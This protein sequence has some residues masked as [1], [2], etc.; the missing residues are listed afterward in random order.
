MSEDRQKDKKE[1]LSGLGKR[2]L[3]KTLPESMRK[4]KDQSDKSK[5]ATEFIPHE[6]SVRQNTSPPSRSVSPAKAKPEIPR[7][8]VSVPQAN[9][10][11]TS[12]KLVAT[13]KP[14][15]KAVPKK[16]KKDR[17]LLSLQKFKQRFAS[18]KDSA[19]QEK[20][21][22]KGRI[23]RSLQDRKNI[24]FL[25]L[26]ILLVFVSGIYGLYTLYSSQRQS[27]Y[28]EELRSFIIP[29]KPENFVAKA[30]PVLIEFINQGS[31]CIPVFRKLY[32]TMTPS[33]KVAVL[34]IL[35]EIQDPQAMDIWMDALQSN[36]P[37]LARFA[38]RSVARLEEKAIAPLK[39]KWKNLDAA[40]KPYFIE[41]MA[42]T[43]QSEALPLILESLQ[44]E[45]T[46]TRE[47]SAEKLKY[48][49]NKKEIIDPLYSA[50]SDKESSVA[51]KALVV[52]DLLQKEQILSPYAEGLSQRTKQAFLS[53]QMPEIRARLLQLM[54]ILGLCLKKD[55]DNYIS[56]FK[57]DVKKAF[58]EDSIPEKIAAAYIL[59]KFQDEE[60]IPELILHIESDIPEL[61]QNIALS[62]AALAS[63]IVPKEILSRKWKPFA[64]VQKALA[65]ILH[66]Y[67]IYTIRLGLK[68]KAIGFLKEMMAI[69]FYSS[70]ESI[71]AALSLYTFQPI[72][73]LIF[74]K[75]EIKDFKSLSSKIKKGE[76]N[77]AQYL[78]KRFS[79]KT[80]ALDSLSLSK[81]PSEE[82]K[83]LLLEEMN[84][85]LC[86]TDLYSQDRFPDEKQWPSGKEIHF[87]RVLIE[88]A[89]PQEIM[90]A[91][92]LAYSDVKNPKAFIQKFVPLFKPQS[93][94]QPNKEDA[95]DIC[96]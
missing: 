1:S 88:K 79:E 48:F 59:G 60:M 56:F 4:K 7:Q 44:K 3:K 21:K 83:I 70:Q 39:E 73:M 11:S 6:T 27:K 91:L 94:N 81:D 26:G 16:S 69:S 40:S 76:G 25:V 84:R 18:K 72:D 95:V 71:A 64:H 46:K 37:L 31:S 63:P 67:S 42:L 29:E 41:A 75:E 61:S 24:T 23:Y 51:E 86:S 38:A 50:L 87:H 57:E 32:P 82:A 62:L 15:K 33:Q 53:S 36:V 92:L 30:H 45:D 49:K 96:L 80:D 13:P 89:F 34:L 43:E 47:V 8:K 9:F 19:S 28:I 78:K 68:E 12:P 5:E 17:A 22:A 2:N 74:Q 65:K 14:E 52:L 10:A 58:Q 20:E 93:Q 85:I 77:L 90:P 54:G 66:E 55:G 35:G